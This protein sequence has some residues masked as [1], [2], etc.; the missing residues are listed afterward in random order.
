MDLAFGKAPSDELRIGCEEAIAL[1]WVRGG[2][3]LDGHSEGEGRGRYL[4]V[5]SK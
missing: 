5:P 4:E 1:I 2:M 3:G